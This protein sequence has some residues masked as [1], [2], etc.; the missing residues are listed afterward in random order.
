MAERELGCVVKENSSA[1]VINYY[2]VV[3]VFS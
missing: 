1:F 2:E 3:V